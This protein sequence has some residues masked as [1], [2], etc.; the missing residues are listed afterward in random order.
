MFQKYADNAIGK[1]RAPGTFD[2]IVEAKKF[3]N[4]ASVFAFL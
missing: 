1:S 3:M 2:N 4:L